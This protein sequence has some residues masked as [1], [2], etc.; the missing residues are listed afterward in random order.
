MMQFHTVVIGG[1]PGGLSCAT[2]L[3]KKGAKVLLLERK[4]RLGA[5]VCAGGVTWSGLAAKLPPELIERSFPTQKISSPMQTAT[6]RASKPI[7]ST[8]NRKKLGLHMVQ[9]AKD[10][11]AEIISGATVQEIHEQHVTTNMGSFGYRFLVGADGSNSRVRRFLNIPTEKIGIGINCQVDETFNDMEW[12]LDSKLFGCGYAWIFPHGN[13]TSVGAY[14]DRRNM[15]ANTL[16]HKFQEWCKQRQINIADI[17]PRAAL[18][19]YDFRGYRFGNRFLAGDAAGL[20]SGLTGEGV[21]P[22]IVS[23][24]TIARL[25][26]D[27]NADTQKLDRLIHKQHVHK[28]LLAFVSKNRWCNRICAETIILGLRTGI[29]PFRTLEMGVEQPESQHINNHGE[30]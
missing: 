12:C 9:K 20:A 15:K 22:A 23:G 30:Q 13:T 28:R 14:I 27:P 8:V 29:I 25:I 7:I 5:K 26:I 16:L 10:A 11:G 17:R 2:T 3:A 4:Q 24:E 21:Y 19:N 6:I 1:G 18:I